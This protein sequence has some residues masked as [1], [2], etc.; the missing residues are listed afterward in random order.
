VTDATGAP[1]QSAFVGSQSGG[2]AF[3][4]GQ[5]FYRLSNVPLDSADAPRDWAVTVVPQ[6]S[7]LTQQ[8][9]VATVRATQT[10]VLDFAFGGASTSTLTFVAEGLPASAAWVPNVNGLAPIASAP[11]TYAVHVQ[12]GT[13][14]SFSAPSPVAG[15]NGTR[16]V[17]QGWRRSSDGT[18]VNS[19]ITINGDE[20]FTA[21]YTPQLLL[22]VVADPAGAVT[23]TSLN[24]GGW[25]HEGELATVTANPVVNVNN[26]R[27]EFVGWSGD[28]SGALDSATVLMSGAQRPQRRNTT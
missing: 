7:G 9:R 24:G 28:A 17:L 10:T 12:P 27:Y 3:T 20:R 21:V 2:S 11:N 8:T 25:Y 6:D 5:G 26:I 19:P 23:A 15:T 1:I 22:T 18:G 13:V 14:A 16:Y 4:D